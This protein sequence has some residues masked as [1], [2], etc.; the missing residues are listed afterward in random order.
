M[1]SILLNVAIVDPRANLPLFHPTS[2]FKHLSRGP[3]LHSFLSQPQQSCPA[4]PAPILPANRGKT[5]G[6]LVL[7][8]QC[9]PQAEDFV[10]G[11]VRL[12]L[13]AAFGGGG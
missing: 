1:R 9:A 8:L 10:K 2:C 3:F 7:V 6:I 12:G 5:G 11:G 4:Q 13:R